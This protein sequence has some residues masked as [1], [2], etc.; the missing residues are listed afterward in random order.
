[1]ARS[2]DGRITTFTGRFRSRTPDSAPVYFDRWSIFRCPPPSQFARERR[3]LVRRYTPS[4][5]SAHVDD[6]Y[7]ST[8]HI[9]VSVRS[10]NQLALVLSSPVRSSWVPAVWSRA[11]PPA[12]VSFRTVRLLR[13]C[14]PPPPNNSTRSVTAKRKMAQF[15]NG[16]GRAHTRY[17][18]ACVHNITFDAFPCES[19]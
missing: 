4:W 14:L 11:P 10:H 17:A 7:V 1:M 15:S 12:A 6:T 5:T 13:G 19:W 9:P 16:R 18:A 2:A 8:G 3:S